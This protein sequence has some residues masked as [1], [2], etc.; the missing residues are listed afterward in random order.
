MKEL[1]AN[2]VQWCRNCNR[3]IAWGHEKDRYVPLNPDG[4]RHH[5]G[6]FRV[7]SREATPEERERFGIR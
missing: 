5:C 6:G 7:R 1:E 2:H 3:R 4:T